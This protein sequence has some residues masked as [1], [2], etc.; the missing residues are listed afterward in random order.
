MNRCY[1]YKRMSFGLASAPST[2]V[3]LINMV[4][5]GIDG[6]YAYMDDILI[7]SKSKQEHQQKLEEVLKRFSYHGLELSLKKCQFFKSKVEYLGFTFTPDGIRTQSKLLKPM[8]KPNYQ[9][10]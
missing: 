2:W 9:K 7:F 6:V 5:S 4:L 10:P 1:M 3:R 8:F